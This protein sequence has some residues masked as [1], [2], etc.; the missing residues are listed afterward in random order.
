MAITLTPLPYPHTAL[1]P[2]ISAVTLQTHHGRHHQTY[3]DN[4]NAA[5]KDTKLAEA[6][7]ADIISAAAEGH[8]QTLFNNAAQVWNHG[9]YW[10]SLSPDPQQ[11][12]SELAAAINRTF[13]SLDALKD[14]LLAQGLAHFGSGWVWLVKRGDVLSVEQ[15]HDAAT[16]AVPGPGGD[17]IPL[18]VIDLW[19]H[20]YY[21]DYKNVRKSYLNKLIA[22]HL[23]WDFASGNLA[24]ETAWVYPDLV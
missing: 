21:L 24:G 11:P 16:F 2:A 6:A 1:V 8:D 22:D 9:F 19:E 5:T 12:G 15:T 7:L 4:V 18:L 13:G 3:V 14:E 23:A 20:A 10:H 17:A